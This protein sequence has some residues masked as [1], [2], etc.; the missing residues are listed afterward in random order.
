MGETT[1]RKLKWPEES[2]TPDVP[3][4]IQK[5]AEELDKVGYFN[6]GTLASRPEAAASKEGDRYWATDDASFSA[7]GTPYIFFA[8]KWV[9]DPF[10]LVI[11]SMIGNEAVENKHIKAA[12]IAGSKLVAKEPIKK[13]VIPHTFTV[14]G[15]VAAVTLP[16]FPVPVPAAQAVKFKEIRHKIEAGTNCTWKILLGA[17]EVEGLKA[18]K[19]TTTATTT[20]ATVGKSLSA[21][22]LISLVITAIEGEPKNLTVAVWLE[23]EF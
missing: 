11:A 4:D 2:A 14:V 5:L 16:P 7:E 3:R 9:R 23:Y 21:A 15:V 17:S 6:S 1:R 22:E 10:S 19:Y 18:I 8:G 13:L 12:T 20:S